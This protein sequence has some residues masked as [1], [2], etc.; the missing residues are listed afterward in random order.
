[1]SGVA[2]LTRELVPDEHKS[3]HRRGIVHTLPMSNTKRMPILS[4]V[5]LT[6]LYDFAATKSAP[7]SWRVP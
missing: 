7:S 3:A 1:M 6:A 4:L 2:F 5:L